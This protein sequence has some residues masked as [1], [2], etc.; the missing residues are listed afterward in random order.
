MPLTRKQTLLVDLFSE[1]PDMDSNNTAPGS[2]TGTNNSN[3]NSNVTPSPSLSTLTN[4]YAQEIDL[5]TKHGL[6]LFLNMTKGLAEASRYDLSLH[7]KTKRVYWST[8]TADCDQYDFRPVLTISVT[9]GTALDLLEK[10]ADLELENLVDDGNKLWGVLDIENDTIAED[11]TVLT[12]EIYQKRIRASAMGQYLLNT[13]TPEARTRINIHKAQFTYRY[14]D[15]RPDLHGPTILFLITEI[16]SP[17]SRVGAEHLEAQLKALKL[18]DFAG[19]VP[20]ALDRAEQLYQEILAIDEETGK[21]LRYVKI[22]LDL[23]SSGTVKEFTDMI[24]KKKSKWQRGKTITIKHLRKESLAMWNNLEANKRI[25]KPS[26]DSTP[27]PPGTTT[28]AQS[29]YTVLTAELKTISEKLSGH[30]PSTNNATGGGGSSS[31]WSRGY[32]EWRKKKIDGKES[33]EMEGR[34]WYWVPDFVCPRGSF[35][36]MYMT[37]K[38]EDHAEWLRKKK[39]WADRKRRN[40]NNGGGSRAEDETRDPPPTDSSGGSDKKLIPTNKLKQA[41]MTSHGMMEMQADAFL[42]SLN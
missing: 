29:F 17:S 20:Q 1:L 39:Y 14:T 41:L 25:L 9:G 16:I 27:N 38:P 37:H 40:G 12:K 7:D 32:Q 6:T 4:P 23:L 28:E 5:S 15:G 31:G 26:Q 34:T 3:N 33:V 13:L 24:V 19:D 8:V 2:G 18:S 11:P 21:S 35:S 30:K 36:G 10:H 22:M 42:A